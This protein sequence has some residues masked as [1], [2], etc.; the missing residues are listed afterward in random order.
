M[1]NIYLGPTEQ[2]MKKVMVMWNGYTEAVTPDE[3]PHARIDGHIEI[4]KGALGLQ[5]LGSIEISRIPDPEY[6]DYSYLAN[7]YSLPYFF[8][9][10][11]NG[12][13][14]KVIWA[15]TMS[16]SWVAKNASLGYMS[17]RFVE[18]KE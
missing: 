14:Y 11:V 18:V 5:F 8:L 10:D 9:K 3:Q 17:F 12:N 4:T 16:V 13:V 7:L 15:E 6:A 2:S 1:S